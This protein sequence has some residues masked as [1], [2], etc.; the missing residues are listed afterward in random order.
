MSEGIMDGKKPEQ[1]VKIIYF[2]YLAGFVLGGITNLIGLVMA[3]IYKDEAPE[4][5]QSHYRFQI[6]TFWIGGLYAAVGMLLLF[7]I[8]LAFLAFPVFL[9]LAVWLIIRC[10]K[11]LKGINQEQAHPNPTSWLF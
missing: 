7:S 9:F 3:Y 1:M 8:F 11:G 2:L 6:R 5:L 10:V 4:W